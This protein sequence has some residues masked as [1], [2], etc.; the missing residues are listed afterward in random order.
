VLQKLGFVKAEAL[1]Q[2]SP[3]KLFNDVCGYNKKNKLGLTNPS[4][5]DIKKWIEN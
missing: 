1:K 5:E 3:G 4:L 2:V